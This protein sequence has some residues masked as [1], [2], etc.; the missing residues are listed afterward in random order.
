MPSPASAGSPSSPRRPWPG[1]RWCVSRR[2]RVDRRQRDVDGQASV[3]EF[4]VPSTGRKMKP[5]P[6]APT[7]SMKP[8]AATMFDDRVGR[9][10]RDTHRRG[11]RVDADR[12]VGRGR[13]DGDRRGRRAG[14][15]DREDGRRSGP[16]LSNESV[17]TTV[18]GW[19]P[20]ERPAG[21][22]ASRLVVTVVAA[23]RHRSRWP[24]V[25]GVH[26]T[27]DVRATRGG[28]GTGRMERDRHPVRS[29]G[30]A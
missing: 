20:S 25:D 17:A 10:G 13:S 9:R 18:I 24:V 15:V 5:D 3:I 26:G 1:R 12:A 2:Q 8:S 6:G 22:V 4:Q 16:G 19:S 21:I 14:L 11:R 23:N 28:V 30:S 7:V 29:M 27:L